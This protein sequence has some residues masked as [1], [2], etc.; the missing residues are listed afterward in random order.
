LEI[1]IVPTPWRVVFWSLYM[2][3]KVVDFLC[4][5]MHSLYVLQHVQYCQEVDVMSSGHFL[6]RLLNKLAGC[7]VPTKFFRVNS[8]VIMQLTFSNTALFL[9]FLSA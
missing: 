1:M 5:F 2:I 6:K 4:V 9:L 8:S 3:S 7:A